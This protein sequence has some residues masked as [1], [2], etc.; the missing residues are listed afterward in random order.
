[1]SDCAANSGDS[2]SGHTG[3]ESVDLGTYLSEVASAL[4]VKSLA[5]NANARIETTSSPGQGTRVVIHFDRAD[6][7]A[8]A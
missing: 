6:A 1:M 5:D 2:N 4:I 3:G 8:S 7:E